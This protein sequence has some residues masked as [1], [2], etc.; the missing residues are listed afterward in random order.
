MPVLIVVPGPVARLLRS[1]ISTKLRAQ[2]SFAIG[3]LGSKG[4]VI[5]W[6]IAVPLVR[7]SRGVSVKVVVCHLPDRIVVVG[8]RPPV[9]GSCFCRSELLRMVS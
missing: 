8:I 1:A 5:R 9:M 7:F 2:S 6:L 4:W 3:R